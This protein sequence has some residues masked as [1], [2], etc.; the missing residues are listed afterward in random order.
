MK[1][2]RMPDQTSRR[3][4]ALLRKS[5]GGFEPSAGDKSRT[6]A[7]IARRVGL[8]LAAGS[9]IAAGAKTAAAAPS[10]A[11]TALVQAAL[12]PTAIAT[13][14]VVSAPIATAGTVAGVGFATKVVATVMI[15]GTLSVGAVTVRHVSRET[16]MPQNVI[17]TPQKTAVLAPNANTNAKTAAPLAIATTDAP[18]SNEAPLAV[19]PTSV[20]LPVAAQPIAIAAIN[21]PNAVAK[22]PALQTGAEV[23]L[24]QHAQQALAA[25]D[26]ST[27]LALLNE[28]ARRFPNGALAEERDAARVLAL[29][30]AG[31]QADASAMGAA[32]LN[33]YPTSPLA[34]RVRSSCA[35]SIGAANANPS[36]IP[37]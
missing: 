35:N 7:A 23:E 31:R 24:I 9:V 15:L 12:A 25:N 10:L 11:P 20:A 27:A 13:T 5:A 19:T 21:K 14:A 6:R 1:E 22:P 34:S 30:G 32:F 29:C 33:R 18:A 16:A 26:A 37:Q 28:H 4:S 8:G 3:A 17:D 36:Q 2:Q